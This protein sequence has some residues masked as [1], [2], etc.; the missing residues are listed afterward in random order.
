MCFKYKVRHLTTQLH[1]SVG[2]LCY[3]HE[4]S[5]FDSLW[6]HRIF[7]VYLILLA[8][9]WLSTRKCFWGVKHGRCI[10]LTI[11]LPFVNWLSR[12]C[13]VLDISQPYRPPRPLTGIAI[14][15]NLPCYFFQLA[16]SVIWRF[17]KLVQ[18]LHPYYFGHCPLCNIWHLKCCRSWLFFKWSS[19]CRFIIT[20]LL[21]DIGDTVWVE[22]RTPWILNLFVSKWTTGVSCMSQVSRQRLDS[23]IPSY[24]IIYYQCQNRY[25]L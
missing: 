2:A 13:E 14:L 19:L 11:S 18:S 3:K 23:S 8:A 5:E 9:Q 6:D 22:H 16:C 25:L 21:I 24:F 1:F 4:G 7:S 20:L 10:R 17:V 12:Q 15:V